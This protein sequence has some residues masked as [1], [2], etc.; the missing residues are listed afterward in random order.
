MVH[1]LAQLLCRDA[2]LNMLLRPVPWT[3]TVAYFK[4][5]HLRKCQEVPSPLVSFS[6]VAL[7]GLQELLS[8]HPS[9]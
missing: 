7:A 9:G 2:G 3:S 5:L 8:F 4:I 1:V 6:K